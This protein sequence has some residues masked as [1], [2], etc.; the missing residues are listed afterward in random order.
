MSDELSGLEL[1][2]VDPFP[3]TPCQGCIDKLTELQAIQTQIANMDATLRT[4]METLAKVVAA[5]NVVGEQNNWIVSNAEKV[6]VSFEAMRE[7]FSKGGLMGMMKGMKT[8][9]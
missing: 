7:Q 8:D 5:L 9:G 2:A 4:V 1:S 6:F 3:T